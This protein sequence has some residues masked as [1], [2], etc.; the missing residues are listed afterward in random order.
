MSESLLWK[1]CTKE[2]RK[3]FLLSLRLFG[4]VPWSKEKQLACLYSVSNHISRH[5]HTA[6]IPK[7]DGSLRPLAVPD[8]LLKNIQKGIL[9]HLLDQRSISPYATAYHKKAGILSN[10]Q[11]HVNK[12]ILLKLDIQDFFGSILFHMVL[13]KAFPA[14]YYPEA[15]GVL[16]TNLCCFHDCLPQGSPA[17]P[18]IS[19]LIMAPFDSYMG[20]WCESRS[21]AYTRYCDDLTFSGSFDPDA[22]IRKTGGFLDEMGFSLNKK[23]TR[24]LTRQTRQTV[25]GIIV[26]QKLQVSKEYRR[27]VRQELYYCEKFGVLSHLSH[28]GDSRYLS[29]G[30]DGPKKYL[31]SLL[32]RVNHIRMVNPQDPYFQKAPKIIEA[33]HAGM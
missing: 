10:A 30:Q 26:N 17:S 28:I 27:K 16:L 15:A 19:N 23:K 9:R 2:H 31:S 8:P 29:L 22:V 33:L 32:G 13:K 1:Y 24:V 6:S 4:N 14:I 18:A 12:K 3:E 11:V 7:K 5:Y 21:I 20:K 25:T